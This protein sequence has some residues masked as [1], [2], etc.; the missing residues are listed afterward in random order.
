M[1]G[2][3]IY[4]FDLD[5]TIGS[6]WYGK[7]RPDLYIN[8]HDATVRCM[9][10]DIYANVRPIPAAINF[11]QAAQEM[12]KGKLAKAVAS[13][14]M[15]GN[16]YN[17]KVRF[18]LS[19]EKYG[20]HIGSSAI[21]GT[22]CD[23]DKLHVLSSLMHGRDVLYFDDNHTTVNRVNGWQEDIA[24]KEGTLPPSICLAIH[25]SCM[26]THT[27]RECEEAL[28]CRRGELM[29]IAHGRPYSRTP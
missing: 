9:H 11:I 7:D 21:F 27:P 17:D 25:A 6:A 20:I 10:E 4:A 14:V 23:E 22:V 28:A 15:A 1:E 13:T 5:G 24:R 8:R 16:E 19:L 26:H 18:V 3:I 2:S 29:D 12:H